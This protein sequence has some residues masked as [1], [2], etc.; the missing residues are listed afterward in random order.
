M[1]TI[2]IS[3]IRCRGILGALLRLLVIAAFWNLGVRSGEL[4]AESAVEEYDVKA[5]FL[6]N[7]AQFVKWPGGSS[8]TIG[9]LGDDPFGGKLQNALQGKL[10][11]RH[12]K[13]PDDLKNCQIVFV[14]KS[15]RGNVSAILSSL[16][17]ANVLTVGDSDGFAKQGGVIG[18]TMAGDKVRFEIN[19]AAARRAGLV[20]SSQLLKLASRIFSS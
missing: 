1:T 4:R 14:S 2:P 10:N 20:I 18:F 12:S 3:C 13:R 15:E 19:T 9:I 11:I 7:F 6:A 16:G 8:G 17:E 5:A